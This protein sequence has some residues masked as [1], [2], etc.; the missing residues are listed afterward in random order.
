MVINITPEVIEALESEKKNGGQKKPFNNFSEKNYLNTRLAPGETK[1]EIRIRLL[2]MDETGNPFKKVHMHK[3]KVPK[4]V[5]ENGPIYGKDYVCLS[6]NKDIDHDRFGYK[7]PLC[8]LNKI[9]Y[10]NMVK[11]TDPV[12][13]ELLKKQ[14]LSFKEREVV[15]VRCIERGHESEGVKFWKFNLR[16]DNTDPYN[17]MLGLYYMRKK[18][19]EAKGKV[20]NIFDIYNGKDL[21]VTFSEGNAA[22]TI[23]DDDEYSPVSEDKEQIEAW[24]NDEKKWFDVFTAKPYEYLSLVSAM[25]VP[26]FDKEKGIWVSKEE[27]DK[28]H[29]RAPKTDETKKAESVDEEVESFKEGEEK[30]EE[31]AEDKKEETSTLFEEIS[32]KTDDIDLPF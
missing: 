3:I 27:F 25:K 26:W 11:E 10:D 14:S 13:K 32:I 15:I 24:Q 16:D 29:G 5:T 28:E 4:E 6:K 21:I 9:A 1:K 19:G 7:C 22:P 8:E 23:V 20:V 18:A 17:Q 2:P 30:K 31:S 12:K